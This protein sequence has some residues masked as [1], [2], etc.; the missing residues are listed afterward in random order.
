MQKIYTLRA[1]GWLVSLMFFTT[2]LYAQVRTRHI[3]SGGTAL[4]Q[5]GAFGAQSA[6]TTLELASVDATRLIAEDQREQKNGRPPRVAVPQDA[7]VDV[8]SSG[9]VSERNG[10]R[11]YQFEI[12]SPGAGAL[13]AKFDRLQ[14]AEGAQVFLYNASQTDLIGP[15]T[16]Q[17]NISSG[18]FSTGHVVGDRLIIELQEPIAVAGQSQLHVVSVSNFYN[19]RGP[20]GGLRPAGACENNQAC[21]PAYQSEAEGVALIRVDAGALGTFICTGATVNDARQSFRSFFLTAFHCIDFDADQTIDANESGSTPNWVFYFKYQSPDCVANTDD[22]VYVTISGATYRAGGA[23][24]DFNLLELNA[25]APQSENISFLG[26]DRSSALSST[27]FGIHHPNGS[28]KK[29]S[30]GGAT[31]TVGVT[32]GPGGYNTGAGTSF[33]QLSWND[34]VTEGGSSGSPLFDVTS[35]RIVGQLL[36]GSSFCTPPSAQNAPDQYGRFFTS[37]TGGGTASTRLSNW[38]DPTGISGNTTNLAVPTVSGPAAF[39]NTGSFAL[40]TLDASITSWSIVGVNGLAFTAASGSGNVANLTS[41]GNASNVVIRFTVNAGQSYAVEFT[42]TFNVT[43]A[44]PTNTPPSPPAGGIPNQTATVGAA[45]SYQVPAFTDPD[46]GQTLTYSVTGLP[47]NGLSFNAGTRTVSGTPSASGTVGVTVTANDGNGGTAS[48][49]F[50]ITVNAAPVVPPANT[51][52]TVASAIAPQSGTVGVGFSF[53]IPPGTFTDAETP[54][55]LAISVGPLPPGLSASGGLITGTPSASGVSTVTVTATDPGSLSVSTTFQLT[56]DPAPVVPPANTAPTV[57][58]AIAPQSGTV[59]V[60]FSFTIPASTFTDA[61]TPGSLVVSVS[62]L[63]AGLSASGSVISG[64]PSASG[65][66]TVTV[67]ATDPGSLSVSTTFQLTINP[68]SVVVPPTGPFSITGVTTISCTTLSAGQRQVSFTPQYAGANGQPISFSVANELSPTTAPGPYTL[69]LF[70]DNPTITLK[71]TQSGTAGEASFAYNWLAACGGV[72]P[73]ANQ[74]PVVANSIPAQSGTVGV[75]F[76]YTIPPGTFSDPNG[77]ALTVSV[78]GLPVGLSASGSV[79]SGTPSASGVSTV[80]VTAT[81]PGSLSVSTT[82][83][84]T[85]NPASVVVPPTGPFSITGVT[86]I[87]CTTLSAGQRQVSFT[88]QYAGVNGQPISFSV[89]NELSPTTAPGPYTLNLFTDNPTIT[90]KATQSGT[91][92]E[93]SFAYNWLAACGGGSTP[94]TPGSFAITGVTTISCTTLSAG[95]RQVSFT[96]QY[97]GT[98]GQPISF[99]VANELLPTTAPGPYTLNLFTDNP[100]ITLKATQSGTAGEASFAYNWLVACNSGSARIAASAGREMSLS[101]SVLGNPAVSETVQVEVR[102]AEGQPL[103]V[104]VVNL[105]G[106]LLTEERIEQSAAVERVSVKLGRSVGVYLLQ[107]SSPGQTK[108]VRLLKSE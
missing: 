16:S 96:P 35:R 34:G 69:N 86:T 68:A 77:D 23:A 85:I 8:R 32:Y 88:P 25:Q 17:Q 89:A 1:I 92:G 60:G 24:S 44:A 62:G 26:W 107:V 42:K 59:G 3:P 33:L 47:A 9:T 104:S 45:F 106:G 11:V 57:A 20:F 19:P 102:G 74:A 51:A 63:P 73:P 72:T 30:F 82:F 80:T 67:T 37:W 53:S 52:P 12:R 7:S 22:N 5:F 75:G 94:P 36:G 100:I 18:N 98:T 55:S 13:S 27:T 70:T 65:V 2:S 64:T 15:I 6:I 21:F 97:A 29:I 95:Q 48:S 93:A 40:N 31:T 50:T 39:T 108:V 10:Y 66:S 71:A 58:S 28:L 103:R 91:A 56:I 54:G 90:L 46:A 14:L 84:L 61:E 81:D 78:A 49:S 83:Q 105:Q 4:N 79:I 99:S 87:S 41:V 38:L 76:N 101:V 43:T